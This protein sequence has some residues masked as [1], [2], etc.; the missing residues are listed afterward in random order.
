[1]S[2]N[3]DLEPIRSDEPPQTGEVV[4]R[5]NGAPM[6]GTPFERQERQV[7]GDGI[8]SNERVVWTPNLERREQV[9]HDLAADRS[10]MLARTVN[11]IRLIVGILEGLAAVRVLLRL[12][13][14]NAANP[15]AHGLYALT[16]LYLAPF[17]GLVP[18]PASGRV[19]F[20]V[21]TL[22]GMIFIY[23]LGWAIERLVTVALIRADARRSTMYER[24][25]N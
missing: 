18:N 25:R 22:I 14:A 9:I 23:L 3:R 15:F 20:E 7:R 10:F 21:S 5:R 12:V 16:A 17:F 2:S 6:N 11:I 8:E 1:M 13:G 4:D 24:E 19:V